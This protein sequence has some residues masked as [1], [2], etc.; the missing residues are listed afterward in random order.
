[1]VARITRQRKA[2]LIALGK[3]LKAARKAKRLTMT[4]VAAELQVSEGHL[5][6]LLRGTRESRVLEKSVRDFIAK[7]TPQRETAAAA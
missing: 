5:Y 1:M 4:A 6:Q 2:E 7:H 3:D